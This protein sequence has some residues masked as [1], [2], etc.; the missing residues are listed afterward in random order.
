MAK[1]EA[2]TSLRRVPKPASLGIRFFSSAHDAPRSRRPTDIALLLGSLAAFGLTVA[3]GQ[4]PGSLAKTLTALLQGLPDILQTVWVLVFDGLLAWTLVLLAGSIVS[5]HRLHLFRDQTLAAILALVAIVASGSSLESLWTDLSASAPPPTHPAARLALASAVL[6][7]TSPH[8][9]VRVR[10]FGRVLL[11]LG[12]LATVI[13]GV[14]WPAGVI[15]ALAIGA[16]S[17][18]TVHLVFGSPGGLP[19]K[20]QVASALEQLGIAPQSIEVATLQP[21][22]VALMIA[23][24]DDGRSLLVKVYG[25]DAWDGQVI[26]NTWSYLWY[27]DERP[28][29]SLSR[30]QQVEHEA[31]LTLLAERVGVNVLPVVA[32]GGSEGDAL[33]VLESRGRLVESETRDIKDD[34]VRRLWRDVIA[35]HGAGIAHGAIAPER[36]TI[37][38]DGALALTDFSGSTAAAAD[39]DIQADRAQLVATTTILVGSDRAVALARGALGSSGIAEVLPY[40]QTAALTPSERSREK[41]SALDLTALRTALANAAEAEVPALVPMRRVTVGSLLTAV[42]LSAVAWMLISALAD[43][44]LDTIVEQIRTADAALL[45][46]ALALS[47]LI[48]VAETFSTLGATTLAL[49]FGPVLEL[50]FAIRFIALAVPSSAARIAMNVRF[51]QRAGLPATSALA[52]GAIDS[53]SGFIVQI[54]LLILIAVAGTVTLDLTLGGESA[55]AGGSF[56]IL[57]VALVVIAGAVIAIVPRFR[58]ML[59]PRLTEVREAARVLKRPSKIAFLFGG[60]LVA[61]LV[62]AGV[63]GLCLRAFGYQASLA[64]LLLVNTL[65]SLLSGIIPVPGGIG[66]TEATMITL[67][68]AIGIPEPVAVSTAITYRVITFYLP[69]AWG[70]F[71]ARDLKRKGRL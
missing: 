50:Q 12:T 15:A 20:Q 54:L 21:R 16:A 56:L 37:D 34:A 13:L 36:L 39:L 3:L 59:A 9:G 41:D 6:I 26:A 14:A 35:M 18:A 64:E 4:E 70:V 45:V 31:L 63:L 48:Q 28:Q 52:V 22:G 25:R 67:L 40:L 71:A 17:A 23:H 55:G 11:I 47:P 57:G 65:T 61:Q 19:T 27:R 60:N 38:D 49:R 69:P 51:L 2:R 8:L 30:L 42:L 7:A 62:A 1:D 29:L 33:L 66:V 68:V 44:G 24:L 5:R 58:K 53:V 43:I 10:H 32:A 46:A